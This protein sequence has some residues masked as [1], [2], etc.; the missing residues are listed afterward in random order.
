MYYQANESCSVILHFHLGIR[1][2]IITFVLK[3]VCLQVCKERYKKTFPGNINMLN[4]SQNLSNA[5]QKST[6]SPAQLSEFHWN[7]LSNSVGLFLLGT[8]C[9]HL[10]MAVTFCSQMWTKAS[11]PP[12]TN[13]ISWLVPTWKRKIL[14]ILSWSRLH[15]LWGSLDCF[16]S[17]FNALWCQKKS[18]ILFYF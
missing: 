10:W 14:L 3:T 4:Y 11:F 6:Q 1:Y 13:P 16:V 9:L 15:G 18:P 17:Q 8:A 12:I 2:F 7:V 5:L